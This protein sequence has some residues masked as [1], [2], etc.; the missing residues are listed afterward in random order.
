[1]QF[2]FFYPHFLFHTQKTVEQNKS[3]TNSHLN[4]IWIKRKWMSERV[5][6]CTCLR[7]HYFH[8]VKI[9]SQFETIDFDSFIHKRKKN[10]TPNEISST[11]KLITQANFGITNKRG[12]RECL[13]TRNKTKLNK[14]PTLC[15]QSECISWYLMVRLFPNSNAWRWCCNGFCCRCLLLIRVISCANYKLHIHARQERNWLTCVSMHSASL[16]RAKWT[17]RK[18]REFE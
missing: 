8:W 14:S 4:L 18:K 11:R 13:C 6:C 9:V 2:A 17:A 15:E 10:W 7:V 3:Q 16:K 5:W 12:W 1:M